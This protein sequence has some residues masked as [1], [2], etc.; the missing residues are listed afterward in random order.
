MPSTTRYRRGDIVLV[1]FPF[2]NLSSSK[3]R[4][5]LVVSPDAF[6]SRGADLIL[7]A[8][9]SQPTAGSGVVPLARVDFAEG[10]L[11]KPSVVR[12][13]KLFTIHSTLILKRISVVRR[14]RLEDILRELRALFS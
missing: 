6:N 3:R 13:A 12:V 4:P 11:P 9:T 1:A 14:E 5:A 8:I 10:V 7:V 2:T